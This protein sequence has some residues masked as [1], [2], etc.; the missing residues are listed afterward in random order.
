MKKI[1]INFADGRP[2]D[3]RNVRRYRGIVG[4]YLIYNTEISIQYPFKQSRLIYI[5]MSEKATNSIGARLQNHLDG[6]SGNEG[7]LSYASVNSLEF[8]VVNFE[9]LKSI[10]PYQVETLE[11]YFIS[12]F[13]RGF[14]VYPICNNKT[15]FDVLN[16][17]VGR[18]INIDWEYF[19]DGK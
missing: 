8:T 1:S 9:M 5:G 11:S 18:Q 15:G 12:D 17:E 13:V 14:G 16:A 10:W 19:N 6:T 3:S 7:I 2:F 4:L